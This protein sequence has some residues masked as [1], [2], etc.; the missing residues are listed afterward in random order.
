MGSDC[1]PDEREFRY[2]TFHQAIFDI[3]KDIKKELN[4]T[5][6]KNKKYSP[7]ALVN[8]GICKKYKFLLKEIFDKN[9]ARKAKFNY[10]DLLKKNVEKDYEINKKKFSFS[11]P[12]NFIFINKDILEVI[13]AYIDG[14]YVRYLSTFFNIII[15]GGCCILKDP[16]GLRDENPFR[17]IILYNEIQE[18]TGNE[19]DFILNIKDKK[20]RNAAIDYIL[21]NNLWN[22]FKKIKFD[23]IDEYKIINNDFKQEIGFFV[24]C[25][26]VDKID[27][28]M[29]KSNLKNNM[30]F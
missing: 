20:E 7:F 6:I 29:L 26:S 15:G 3:E 16:K 11:F 1:T 12:S 5:N 21:K 18:N 17:Y 30:I 14:K 8:Q 10:K 23:Y 13:A 22:Y 9:E 2:E 27:I 28:Y 19:I 25:C 24:R 4:N